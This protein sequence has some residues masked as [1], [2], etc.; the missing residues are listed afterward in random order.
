MEVHV[1][2]ATFKGRKIGYLDLDKIV[3]H[4]KFNISIISRLKFDVAL[5]KMTTRMEPL[6]EGDTYLINTICLP[7]KTNEYQKAEPV[8]AY[9][10]GITEN[11][12]FP[13]ILQRADL[14]LNSSRCFGDFLCI[15]C[16]PNDPQTCGVILVFTLFHLFETLN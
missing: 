9:G 11:G 7:K 12:T 10:F 1:G 2:S 6:K 15:V 8:T 13:D 4:S 3:I 14:T 5:L 16:K